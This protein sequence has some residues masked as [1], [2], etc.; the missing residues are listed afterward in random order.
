MERGTYI[1]N[2]NTNKIYKDKMSLYIS[3]KHIYFKIYNV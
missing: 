2:K 1:V 3:K